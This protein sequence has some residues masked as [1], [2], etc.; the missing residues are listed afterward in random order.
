[1][2]FILAVVAQATP[3]AATSPQLAADDQ[4]QKMV[5]RSQAST[6]TRFKSRNCKSRAEWDAIR[7]QSLRDAA[8]QINRPVVETRRE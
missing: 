1:M 7:E 6:G 8:E 4:S 2:L 5:C 3:V